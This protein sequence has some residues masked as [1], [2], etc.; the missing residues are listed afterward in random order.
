MGGCGDDQQAA[1]PDPGIGDFREYQ[2]PQQ[3]RPDQAEEDQGFDQ[4]DI[5]EPGRR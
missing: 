4:P 1:D 3:G 2:K 5:G